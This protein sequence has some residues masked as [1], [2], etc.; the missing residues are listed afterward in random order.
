M[1]Q[2]IGKRLAALVLSF[3]LIAVA[4]FILV[5]NTPG[6]P[7]RQ[8]MVSSGI[9]Y[10]GKLDVHHHNYDV[11]YRK[12]GLD[13]PAFYVTWTSC[14]V[15]DSFYFLPD[16]ERRNQLVKL[17]AATGNATAVYNFRK[18]LEEL[19]A[20]IL[21]KKDSNALLNERFIFASEKL[22]H[23]TDVHFL[24]EILNDKLWSEAHPDELTA[25]QYRK[26]RNYFNTVFSNTKPWK[27]WIP[28]IGFN[29]DNRFHYWVF[30]RNTNDGSTASTRGICR[31][32]F[33]NSYFSHRPVTEM[34]GH[35]LKIT[36]IISL[37]AIFLSLFVS[38]PLGGLLVLYKNTWL[39]KTIPLLM[40]FIFAIP[41]FFMATLLMEIFANPDVLSWF[42]VSGIGPIG[43]IP[44]G[45]SWL[46]R[47]C[48]S[49]PYF[50][51]PVI[52]YFYGITVFFTR[53]VQ[54]QLS[55]ESDMDYIRTARA[56]GLSEKAVI[57][58]HAMRNSFFPVLTISLDILPVML[59]GSVLLE[60]LFSI[61]GLGLTIIAAVQNQDH[62][63]LIACFVLLG[64][65]ISTMY[66]V[67]DILYKIIDPRLQL[68]QQ[69]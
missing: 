42:P 12:L 4:G 17:S 11:L 3:G 40:N 22:L 48:I 8:L 44:E 68:G 23:A 6:D 56:K 67:L 2:F 64:F 38:I 69:K 45:T 21:L 43:G 46:H 53:M 13:K 10:S 30:G 66:L 20:V 61:P 35:P 60:S 62:P 33:G 14:A 65:A 18:S 54:A 16:V 32:D 52:T 29:C 41:I 50:V 24:T 19:Q 49:I 57:F 37:L 39:G 31:G 9:S 51:L 55:N 15:P 36:L 58:I 7:V 34:I 1:W 27:H 26:V 28:S 63:V 5:E 47:L 25:M 59:S